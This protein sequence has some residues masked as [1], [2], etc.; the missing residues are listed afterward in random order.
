MLAACVVPVLRAPLPSRRRRCPLRSAAAPGSTTPLVTT[1]HRVGTA[2]AI[3]R[4]AYAAHR[5]RQGSLRTCVS[6]T[7]H[8]IGSA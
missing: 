1:G 7:G 5:Q 4:A 2:Y 6:S 8:R 3:P